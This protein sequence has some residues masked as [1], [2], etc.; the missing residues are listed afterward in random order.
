M[1]EATIRVDWIRDQVF[2]LCDRFDF[3]TIMTQLSEVK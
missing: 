2:L 3:P 1:P